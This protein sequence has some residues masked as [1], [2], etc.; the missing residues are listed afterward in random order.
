[1]LN[2]IH[3]GLHATGKIE[4]AKNVLHMNL[5]GALGQVECPRD[6]LVAGAF[7]QVAENLVFTRA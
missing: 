4:L 2:G 7:G 5:D 6:F 3:S 1:M